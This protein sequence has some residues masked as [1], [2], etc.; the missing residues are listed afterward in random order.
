MFERWIQ[1]DQQENEQ[2][3]LLCCFYFAAGPLFWK[4]ISDYTQQN[5]TYSKI[6]NTSAKYFNKSSKKKASKVMSLVL[7]LPCIK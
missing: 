4:E 1:Q 2:R 6:Q 7:L 5:I 3:N